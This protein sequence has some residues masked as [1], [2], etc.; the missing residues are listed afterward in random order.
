M[1]TAAGPGRA[2]RPGRS[3]RPTG[4]SSGSRC[5]AC[6]ARSR[7]RAPA[8]STP[9]GPPP[10][11][12]KVIHSDRRSGSASRSAASKAMRIRRRMVVASSIVLRPARVAGPVVVAEVL[13]TGAGRDDQRVVGDRPAVRQDDLAPVGIE[14][15]RLAEEHG[16]VP[17]AAQDRAQ[18]LGDVA[19]RERPGRDLVEQG[20]EQVM[21]Q[22][23]DEGD[24]DLGRPTQLA[25]R[26]QAGEPT[27]D[28]DDAVAAC[29]RR[30]SVAGA[31]RHDVGHAPDPTADPSPRPPSGRRSGRPATA[32]LGP[33]PRSMS[34]SCTRP[35][36]PTP[37]CS[38]D[39]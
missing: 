3:G 19:R 6:R 12:T 4:G 24:L 36:G 7:P 20:L 17:V 33:C 26:V 25:G 16:R 14:P 35:C 1:D 31:G 29:A 30:G 27:A 18:R 10:T 37:A 8:S 38:N 13:V 5:A 21:V 32:R 39:P 28:D 34:S 11:T 2:P 23:V 22:P 9:V 15:D